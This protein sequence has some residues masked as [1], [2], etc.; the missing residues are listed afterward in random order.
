MHDPR[1]WAL[2][3]QILTDILRS[4]P[5]PLGSSHPPREVDHNQWKNGPKLYFCNP[6]L[7]WKAGYATPRFGQGAFKSAFQAAFKV[8][9]LH[10]FFPH[11]ASPLGL[12]MLKPQYTV[13]RILTES[14]LVVRQLYR[15]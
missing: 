9:C 14:E 3:I 4:Y 10:D 12:F 8:R 2:D 5:H 6:D 7:L 11:R 13:S 1:N 15:R